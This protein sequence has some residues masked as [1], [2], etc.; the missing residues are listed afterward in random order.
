MFGS[1]TPKMELTNHLG[2]RRII[3]SLTAFA[4]FVLPTS[5]L[6]ES[7]GLVLGQYCEPPPPPC[8][9]QPCGG[10]E[11]DPWGFGCW[12]DYVICACECSP[13]II[14]TQGTGISLTNINGGVNFDL[15]SD[16]IAERMAWTAIGSDEAFLALDRNGNG[17]IDNGIELFGSFTPQP[18]SAHRNGFIALAEFDKPETGGNS[19]GIIDGR[20]AVYWSLQLWKDT[21]HNGVSE[22]RELFTVPSF[23]INWID[24]TYQESRRRDQYG[25]WFR[26][27]AK[28]DDAGHMNVGRWAW[29][30]FLASST[31]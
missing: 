7:R 14:D 25:N 15:N 17:R 11:G 26:Y 27:R 10:G 9:P 8:P 2:L 20:D 5:G 28:I 1:R 18:P 13:I 31:Q 16:G 22:S 30:V 19:D 21:N 12:W 23:G 24:L 3:F 4:L 6:F 29:D